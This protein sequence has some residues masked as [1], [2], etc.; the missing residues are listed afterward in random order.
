[1]TLLAY[2]AEHHDAALCLGTAADLM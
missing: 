1:V 2:A